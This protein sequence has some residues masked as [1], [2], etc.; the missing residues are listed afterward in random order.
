MK[1]L[2]NF[3]A[4]HKYL[5]T[6]MMRVSSLT[7]HLLLPWLPYPAAVI[8]KDQRHVEVVCHPPG[9]LVILEGEAV[10]RYL[11][12]HVLLVHL[13]AR[14]D[15]E[16]FHPDQ[17]A[18]SITILPLNTTFPPLFFHP[19]IDT[20][21]PLWDNNIS[22][23]NNESSLNLAANITNSPLNVIKLSVNNNISSFNH[24]ESSFNIFRSKWQ[25]V[26]Y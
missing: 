17:L 5:N 11:D 7:P 21:S 10:L 14:I 24:N 19:L 20:N 8:G 9:V 15:D 18:G 6:M 4:L 22:F 2:F 25:I 12:Q 13:R 3:L 16:R 1:I 26:L 23:S